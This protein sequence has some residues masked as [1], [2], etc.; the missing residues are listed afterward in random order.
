MAQ[1]EDV[2]GATDQVNVPGTTDQYPNWRR[3]LAVALESWSDDERFAPLCAAIAAQRP[4]W[5]GQR[6][7]PT[8]RE[9]PAAGIPRATYRLQLHAGFGFRAAAEL[10]PYLAELGVSH[11]YC[12]PYLRARPGST[13]GYDIIDHNALNPEIGGPEAFEGF[14]RALQAHGMGQILDL[15]PNHMGVMGADNRWWMDVLENGPASAYA[16]YFDID[17]EQ[18]DSTAH[19]KLMVPVLGDHYGLALERGEIRLSFEPEAGSFALFYHQHRFPVAPREYSRVLEQALRALPPQALEADVR[20]EL[21]SLVSA[22]THLPPLE[23]TQPELVIERNRD[24]EVHKRHLAALC[25]AH[26]ALVSAIGTAVHEINGVPGEPHS[27]D[28][29]HA[30]LEGQA[31]RLAYWR[32][33]SDEINYRRFFD[34]NDL[35]GLRVENEAVFEA[36]HRLVLELVASGKVHGLRVDHPE[37]LYEPA[38]YFRRL[39]DRVAAHGSA[40]GILGARGAALPIYL[41][42]EKIAAGHEHVPENWPVHGTTGYRFANV[43]NGLFVETATRSRFDRIYRSFTGETASFEDVVYASKRVILRNALSS[44]LNVLGSQLAR[45]AQ[46]D[47]RT[48]DFTLNTLRYALIE[49]IACFPVYRTY[50][51]ERVSAQDR[52]Y[53]EWAVAHAKRR[54]QASD[55]SIFDFVLSAL[56]DRPAHGAAELAQQVHEFALKFQQLTAPVTAKGVE[57][58][59]FYRYTRLVSLNEVGGDPGR[60]G[61]TLAAFHGASLDRARRWPHTMLAGSTHDSKR[62]EDVRARINTLS[63]MPAAW[64]LGLRHWSRINRSKKVAVDDVPAPS[65][66]DE[67]LLYQTLLGSWP[68]VPLDEA[69]LAAYRSRIEAYMIKAV[70]EAKVHSSWINVNESYEQAVREFVRGL[71][72]RPHSLFL[73]D[74]EALQR[75]VGWLGMLNSLSQTLIR[76][77]SPGVPDIFQGTELWDY[78]LVDPDNRRAVDWALRRRLLERVRPLLALPSAERVP[79]LRAM[80]ERPED[81]RAKLFVICVGLASRA[82]N[83]TVFERGDYVAMPAEGTHAKR[84][85]AFG[86]RGPAGGVI[87]VAPRFFAA[88]CERPGQLPCGTQVWGDTH[89]PLPWLT[90]GVELRDAISGRAAMATSEPQH[91]TRLPVGELLG[92]FPVALLE[93]S[94][95]T[96]A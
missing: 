84:I 27:F 36:T 53:V 67:Y 71:L 89:L 38:R 70:R 45:I 20:A 31:Y 24:K 79:Q 50:I 90:P 5:E 55:V 60:F 59:A 74:F 2:L 11:V 72:A 96:G 77:A 76:I 8:A 13:H 4:P 10:V 61:F 57:D 47:R 23:A 3:K 33:A 78:S 34:I 63:E 64:R 30:L 52:R 87:A 93:Y 43:I 41:I 81:G 54:S 86:R 25:R 22:F 6:P 18:L 95:Q 32:V 75:L 21:E 37:G 66:N 83:P 73:D 48:R 16:E 28:A 14:V 26:P 94:L 1:L 15:V 85:V 7:K 56:L 92:A 82:R 19:G 42:V 69:A 91:G 88:L 44:E 80:L 17:W 12:S 40:A 65:A 51:G 49:V 9:V 39:Q 46:A 62:S 58:T 68:A 29:L 35:A